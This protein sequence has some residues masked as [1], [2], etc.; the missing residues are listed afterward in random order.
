MITTWEL[1]G[2]CFIQV[3]HYIHCS[4]EEGLNAILKKTPFCPN[5]LKKEDN[6]QYIEDISI[7]STNID[8]RR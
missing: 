5:S 3:D 1:W 2:D 8:F 7:Q 4:I 6:L